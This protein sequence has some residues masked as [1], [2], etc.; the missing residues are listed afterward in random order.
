VG[1]SSGQTAPMVGITAKEKAE[2]ANFGAFRE[3]CPNFAGRT[4]VSTRRGGDPPDFLCLD[5]SGKRI[6]VE[7]VQWISEQQTGPS[8]QLHGLEESYR[9]VLRSAYVQ[10]PNNIGMIFIYA[11]D[12]TALAPSDS[13]V[14]HNELYKFVADVDA[15]WLANPDWSDPQGYDFTDFSGCPSLTSHLDGLC[16]HSRERFNT[17]LGADW[18]TFR[19]HGGA[20]TPDWMR[21]ALLDN[22]GRKVTKYAKPHNKTK[23]EQQQLDEFYL[24]AYYDEALLHNTPYDAP[25]FGFREIGAL[26]TRELTRNEHPFDKVF[27][28][29]P[30]ETAAQVLQLWPALRS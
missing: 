1:M 20:Y 5:G 24:L 12:G 22:V 13:A 23:L 18:L 6:G 2:A 19:M 16:F 8:K 7:L 9:R 26:V 28:Y 27:L 25:G 29:S 10:P 3:V 11:K 4:L 30:L 14:F 21:D 15:A 17:G